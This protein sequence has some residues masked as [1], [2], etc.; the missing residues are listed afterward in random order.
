MPTY[1][2]VYSGWCSRSPEEGIRSLGAGVGAAVSLPAWLLGSEP[3]LFCRSSQGHPADLNT[4]SALQ[5]L[6]LALQVVSLT[7]LELSK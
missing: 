4:E 3:V 1:M 5:S 2:Y 6:N 7:V